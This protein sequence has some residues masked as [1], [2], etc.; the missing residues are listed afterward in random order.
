MSDWQGRELLKSFHGHLGPYVIIGFRLGEHAVQRLQGRPHFGLEAEVRC[1]GA[2]PESCL[3]DGVQF[4]TG[5]TLGKQN[6]RHE[7]GTPVEARFR[8]RDTGEEIVLGLHEA[9]V[10]EAVRLLRE[11]GEHAASDYAW[12]VPLEELVKEEGA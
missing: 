2:P 4:S 10:A 11:V 6:I 3:L 5:C 1:A 7:V 12:E 8:N 9:P